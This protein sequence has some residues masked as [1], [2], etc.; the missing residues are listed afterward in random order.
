MNEIQCRLALSALVLALAAAAHAAPVP[1][2]GTW[3]TTLQARD[4][5]SDGTT[6]AWYDSTRN[7]SWLADAKAIAGTPFDDGFSTSDGRASFASASSWLAALD[8]FGVGGWRMPGADLI[9]LYATT[10]GNSTIPMQPTTGWTNT[11]PFL[12]VPD[13][14]VSGW[15]WRGDP[16]APSE[17][18]PGGP[19]LTF[20]LAADGL[21]APFYQVPAANFHGVWAVHEGDVA[22]AIP[23]PSTVALMAAGA[24]G[25]AL[26]RRRRAT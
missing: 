5:N 12:N 19:L 17:F 21:G 14:G 4:L 9:T 11:G 13:F 8:V 23:E 7:V 25:L 1:G 6:D 2:Q 24:L 3:E 22:A 26:A 10:L 20:V 15:Y 18:D 16:P